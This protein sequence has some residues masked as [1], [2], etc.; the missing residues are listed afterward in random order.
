MRYS[1]MAAAVLLAAV[2]ALGEGT[3]QVSVRLRAEG[4]GAV[5]WRE[6][7]A[8]S[9]A[10]PACNAA[11]LGHVRVAL[12]AGTAHLCNGAAWVELAG[13]GGAFVPAADP[14][15]DHSG[16]VAGHGDGTD[17]GV[18]LYARGTDAAGN[19]T[20]CTADDTGTDDQT[21]PEVGYT[22]TTPGDWTDPDPADV[23]DALDKV[24]GDPR[25]TDARAPT[26]HRDSHETG[27]SDPLVDLAGETITTGTVADARIAATISRDSEAPAAGDITGSLSAGYQVASGAV[28]ITELG[29]DATCAGEDVVR[30]NAGDTAFECA[31][32][33]SGAGDVVGPASST[34][35]AFALFADTT[36]KLLKDSTLLWNGSDLT[37]P[38]STQLQLP[39]GTAVDPP[40]EFP[41]GGGFDAAAANGK[42][43]VVVADTRNFSFGGCGAGSRCFESETAGG[44]QMWIQ[45][46]SATVPVFVPNKAS[47][48]SG[49]GGALAAPA[50]IVSSVSRV[51]ATSTGATI[52]GTLTS[53]ALVNTPSSQTCADS[54]DGSPGALTVTVS[55]ATNL[56][57]TSSDPD[58]CTLTLSETSASDGQLLELELVA[59]AGGVVTLADT[60]GTQNLSAAWTPGVGDSLTLRYNLTASEW[61]ERARADI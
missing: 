8:S 16:Y 53:D 23:G 18:G 47:I 2:A 54:G 42:V 45:T 58:G 26:A 10:L 43:Y 61:R 36:G 15:V 49:L 52:N 9:A 59:T 1:G 51:T 38:T 28:G 57:V 37:L 4:V 44:P 60:P 39:Y 48:T 3:A 56:Y 22:P 6:P 29:D 12:D 46:P 41:N 35:N 7:V 31:A 19:A 17:C 24:A 40:I 50:L 14:A 11:A 33:A 20:G 34:T 13:G 32:L 30:R 21:A 55:G 25:W 27:G 5:Q